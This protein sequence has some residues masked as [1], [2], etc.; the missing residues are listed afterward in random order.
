MGI[1]NRRGRFAL[2]AALLVAAGAAPSVHA[3]PPASLFGRNLIVNGGAEAGDVSPDG[4][5]AVAIPGWT[6][7]GAMTV[8]PYGA[9]GGFPTSGDRGPALRG[10]RFFVGG[11]D[12]PESTATQSVS[13]GPIAALVDAGFVRYSLGGFLGGWTTQRDDARLAATFRGGGRTLGVEEIGPV[14]AADRGDVTG[15][16]PRAA[17]GTV[18][19][20]TRQV[21]ITLTLRVGEEP[22]A[23]YNDG[24]ADELTFSLASIVGS[25]VVANPGAELGECSFDGY[26][27]HDVPGWSTSGAFTAAQYS[28]VGLP[29]PTDPGPAARGGCLF[30]GGP[31]SASSTATQLVDVTAAA[32]IVD[33]G[34]LPYTLS[35]F[36]GGFAGQRDDA[37]VSVAFLAGSDV[38]G[39]ATVGPVTAQDRGDQTGLLRRTATGEVPAGTRTIRITIEAT[40]REEPPATYNDGQV[41]DIRLVLGR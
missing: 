26:A 23:T 36:L 24:Y 13:L 3:A 22:P 35:A 25:N 38:L 4:S 5:S 29:S 8:V 19:A 17:F 14:T 15:L 20:G 10:D 39:S 41:D 31:E 12:S 33:T 2:A 16:L 32:A 11:P 7:A 34:L 18:P 9:P 37:T 30:I 21:V 1:I 28:G 6:V 40:R 27:V